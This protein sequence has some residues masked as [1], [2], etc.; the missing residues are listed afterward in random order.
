MEGDEVNILKKEDFE[1]F[2]SSLFAS[3]VQFFQALRG[4]APR[5]RTFSTLQ[6]QPRLGELCP[7]Y[8]NN[9]SPRMPVSVTFEVLKLSSLQNESAQ[10]IS[11][12]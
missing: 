6:A 5:S 10:F 4:M 12:R 1:Y 2:V 9:F 11:D 8:N 7:I 3:A